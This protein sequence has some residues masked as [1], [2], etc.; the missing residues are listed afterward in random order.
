[1]VLEQVQLDKSL[2]MNGYSLKLQ[3]PII[4]CGK[5]N[6]YSLTILVALC[7][8]KLKTI[9]NPIVKLPYIQCFYFNDKKKD[10]SPLWY[11]D[12]QILNCTNEFQVNFSKCK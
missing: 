5:N 9:T 4:R 8:T 10:N 2:S 7:E 1:M 12:Y 6:I 3:I 11:I